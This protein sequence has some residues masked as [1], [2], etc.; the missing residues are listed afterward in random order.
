MNNA[1]SVVGL[2]IATA[3]GTQ[4]AVRR[5]PTL[6]AAPR[7]T[8]LIVHG[9]GEHSGRYEHVGAQLAGWG[10]AAVSYDH[11]GHGLS[12]GKRGVLRRSDD[13]CADLATVIDGVLPAVVADGADA[14]PLM[15]LG[16]SLG[17]LVAAQFVA[18]RRRPVAALVLSSPAFDPGLSR[19][20]RLQLAVGE[21]LF[22]NLALGNGLDPQL[23]SHD[24]AVVAAY[25]SDPLVHDRISAK[26]ARSILD[27]AEVVF[28]AASTWPVPTLL[29]WA[30][31][32]RL[33]APAGSARFAALSTAAAA[34]P[35]A[36]RCFPRLYHEIFNELATDRAEVF[37]SLSDWLARQFPAA[38]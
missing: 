38:A 29:M 4:L 18:E 23:V 11:R 2:E 5:W 10:F 25:R 21:R 27:G 7:A 17:G 14:R 22:P 8:V 12:A 28:A 3:D 35:V 24:P 30:G 6:T 37:A 9:L 13:L 19:W 1:A 36:T 26:L 16:H 15:L 33:V 32:D 34:Q 31:S 20:Q